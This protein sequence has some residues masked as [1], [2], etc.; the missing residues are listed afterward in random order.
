MITVNANEG[1]LTIGCRVASFV[2]GAGTINNPQEGSTAEALLNQLKDTY[3]EDV[4]LGYVVR[5]TTPFGVF[6]VSFTRADVSIDLDTKSTDFTEQVTAAQEKTAEE[7]WFE[8]DITQ[9][10]LGQWRVGDDIHVGDI[11]QANVWGRTIELPV[12]ETTWLPNGQSTIHLGGQPVRDTT[13]FQAQNK[14]LRDQIAKEVADRAGQVASVERTASSAKSTAD[15]AAADA[16]EAK[17]LAEGA[18]TSEALEAARREHAEAMAQLETDLSENESRLDANEQALA[19]AK[20]ELEND[21]AANEQALAAAKTELTTALN[22]KLATSTFNT[23]MGQLDSSLSSLNDELDDLRVEALARG[24]LQPGNLV[25][26]PRGLENRTGWSVNLPIK[27]VSYSA[28]GGVKAEFHRF[29]WSGT[30][31]KRNIDFAYPTTEYMFE[32]GQGRRY[33]ASVWIRPSVAVPAGGFALDCSGTNVVAAPALPANTWTKIEADLTMGNQHRSWLRLVHNTS[34]PSG[35]TWD[36]CD[37]MVVEAAGEWL[38]VDGG[39]TAKKLAAESVTAN[40]IAAG[41]VTADKIKANTITSGQIAANAITASEL[42]AGSIS[43]S[44]MTLVADNLCPDPFFDQMNTQMWVQNDRAKMVVGNGYQGHPNSV[45][46]TQYP[47]GTANMTTYGVWANH[48]FRAP[49]VPGEKFIAYYMVKT[50]GKWLT[51]GYGFSCQVYF[52]KANGNIMTSRARN[53]TSHPRVTATDAPVGEWFKVG[54]ETVVTAPEEAVSVSIRPTVYAEKSATATSAKAYIGYVHLQRA[55]GAELIVNG[56]VTTEK[57]VANSI[58]GDRI[59]ANTLSADKIKANTITSNQI[60]S[61]AIT[62]SEIASNAVTAVKIAAGAV[63]AD[64]VAA[65]SITAEH[66]SI[67]PGNLWPDVHFNDPSW[68]VENVTRNPN[69]HR[70]E[71]KITADGTQNGA[72][73]QPQGKRDQGIHLQPNTQYRLEAGTWRSTTASGAP[74]SI[75]VYMRSHTNNTTGTVITKLGTLGFGNSVGLNFTTPNNTDAFDCTIGFYLESSAKTGYVAIWGPQLTRRS[76]AELIVDGAIEAKH[77]K[78]GTITADQIAGGTITADKMDVNDLVVNG[79][80]K[81]TTAYID[82]ANITSIDASKITTGYIDAKRIKA[83]SITAEKLSAEAIY[84][85]TAASTNSVRLTSET[86]RIYNQGKLA[87]AL[88]KERFQFFNGA[89]GELAGGLEVEPFNAALVFSDNS[90]IN[91][92]NTLIYWA[93]KNNAI[94]FG[95]LAGTDSN[96]INTYATF[97]R[98]GTQLV[99]QRMIDFQASS[100]SSTVPGKITL[101]ASGPRNADIY[102]TGNNS[103]VSIGSVSNIPAG[104]VLKTYYELGM[105]AID[106]IGYVDTGSAQIMENGGLFVDGDIVVRGYI[107]SQHGT[108]NYYKS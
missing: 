102:L 82:S 57:M 25:W 55:V 4:D 26:N 107:Y 29:S 8:R 96:V 79:L 21:L 74:Q 87:F 58:N 86:L 22:G 28:T 33:K 51:P 77:I 12:T 38:V 50:T 106:R 3:G 62:A 34:I 27:F 20:T 105:D 98:D 95:E 97:S 40:A 70:G 9:A 89:F 24:L 49:C 85:K 108:Q 56:A 7:T 73:Y 90:S 54:G 36:I 66:L 35:A 41:A 19:T 104:G 39:I 76:S 37:P 78:T 64:K 52:Y 47:T 30:P 83:G 13:T 17:V 53:Q 92:S 18:A 94:Q 59:T 31:V 44:K 10:A 23:K 11:I 46:L 84:A 91:L 100:A 67:V 1:E 72:Y 71:L 14:Q 81:V 48:D 68:E 6:D 45:E 103:I 43:A 2:Y 16:A 99:A 42:A 65:N 61:N 80:A 63:T 88:D 93:A 15:T 60:A 5:P 75:S 69:S 32:T 101:K